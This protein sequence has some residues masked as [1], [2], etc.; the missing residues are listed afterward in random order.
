MIFAQSYLIFVDDF[1]VWRTDERILYYIAWAVSEGRT[2]TFAQNH[3]VALRAR[4][5]SYA[6][7]YTF[8]A[9]VIVFPN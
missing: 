1:F 9:L 2:F 4:D 5:D 7:R 8:L 6:R 3:Q